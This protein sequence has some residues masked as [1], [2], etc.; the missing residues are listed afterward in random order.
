M[1]F[2]FEKFANDIDKRNEEYVRRRNI[3]S[4]IVEE[5]RRRRKRDELYHERWQNQIKW[6]KNNGN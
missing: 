1:E 4:H 3:D 5:D 2:D 6:E